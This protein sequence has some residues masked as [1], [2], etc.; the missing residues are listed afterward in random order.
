MLRPSLWQDI[1]GH[2]KLLFSGCAQWTVQ[3]NLLLFHPFIH[4]SSST[5]LN[6]CKRGSSIQCIPGSPQRLLPWPESNREGEDEASSHY[7]GLFLFG[8]NLVFRN[9]FRLE[10]CCCFLPPPHHLISTRLSLGLGFFCGQR[11]VFQQHPS[12]STAAAASSSG[13]VIFLGNNSI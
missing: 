8:D 2:T 11:V 9:K 7:D 12:R 13:R 1:I 5:W 10:A 6:Q 4:P 3:C